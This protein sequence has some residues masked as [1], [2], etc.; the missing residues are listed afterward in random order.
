MQAMSHKRIAVIIATVSSLILLVIMVVDMRYIEQYQ[1]SYIIF[2]VL[3]LFVI[4]Y[5]VAFYMVRAYI[6]QK[7]KPMYKIIHSS[8]LKP[9]KKA[10]LAIENDFNILATTE[11]DMSEWLK[12]NAFRVEELQ[13]LEQYRK[14]YVGNVAHELKTPI[15]SIQGYIATLLDGGID[16][17]AVNMKYLEKADTAIQ[18][19]ISIVKDLDAITRLEAGELKPNK[20][21]FNIITLVKEVFEAQEFLTKSHKVSLILDPMYD[22]PIMVHADRKYIHMVLTNLTVNAIKYNVS[23]G[24]KVRVKFYD[25]DA[26]LLVEVADTGIGISRINQKRIFERF[27]RVDRSRSRE[28]GGTGLGLA[29]VKH[30]IEAHEQTIHVKSTLNKGTSFTF[31]LEK[32]K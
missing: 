23:K 27:Y 8:K 28:Q 20:T 9:S 15:F 32:G 19:M 18:R 11:K 10:K 17:P 6:I 31:T 29:I 16:D 12:Q 30:I 13:R 21:N 14:E 4:V 26:F 24:G 3:T 7:V 5:I 25:M 22:K 1:Y 2:S